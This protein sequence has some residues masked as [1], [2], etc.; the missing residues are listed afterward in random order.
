MIPALAINC[1][2][3]IVPS[4]L[5]FIWDKKS[6]AV[7]MRSEM[8]LICVTIASMILIM[9]MSFLVAKVIARTAMSVDGCQLTV[10]G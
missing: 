9:T 3:I 10:D 8:L 2:G 7:I 5:K 6:D 4:G 1:R